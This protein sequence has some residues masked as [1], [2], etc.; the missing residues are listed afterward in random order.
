MWMLVRANAISRESDGSRRLAACP[1]SDDRG[2]AWRWTVTSEE[3]PPGA[4][5]IGVATDDRYVRG[6]QTDYADGISADIERRPGCQLVITA[7]AGEVL[8]ADLSGPWRRWLREGDVFV[9]EGEEHERLRLTLTPG[10]S[11][12]TVV[13]LSPVGELPLRWVP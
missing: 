8:V 11:R 1:D 9:V 2:E 6:S 3:E 5:Q 10:E 13:E 12:A 7:T 4:R